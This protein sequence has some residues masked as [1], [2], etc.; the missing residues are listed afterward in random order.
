MNMHYAQKRPW[1]IATLALLLQITGVITI[2]VPRV[3]AQT[4][5]H[6]SPSSCQPSGSLSVL[7]DGTNAISYIPKGNWRGAGGNGVSVVNLEGSRITPTL[8]PTPNMVNSCASNAKSGQ[9][10]CTAN[11]TDVYLLAGTA[12]S[13]TIT[14]G[15]SGTIR[16]TGG[17]CT[18][19]GVAMDADH[20]AAVIGLS[21]AGAPG[22]QFLDLRSSPS[23]EPVFASP[24][25]VISEDLVLDPTNGAQG[26][27]LLSAAENGNFEIVNLPTLPVGRGRRAPQ[28]FENPTSAGELDSTA[29]DCSTGVVLAAAEF[30]GPSN[31]Y[32]VDLTQATFTAGSPTGTWA[33]PSQVQS[34]SESFLSAGASGVAVAQGTHIGMV[35]G[36][37]GGASITAI[38]LPTASGSGIPAINDW[39]TCS[40]PGG[41]ATGDDPHTA[42][43]YKSP[44]TRHAIGVLANEGANTLAAIDLTKMLDT[45]TVARTTSGHGCASGTLPST[46]VTLVSVP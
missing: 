12:L 29:E 25:G 17:N 36:E 4:I 37:F 22:F 20:N 10:V 21:V 33:A 14:S 35:S 24:A 46:V 11:N 44:N 19:C 39:V 2:E 18:N 43:A 23:F 30:S 3:A 1:Q 13:N 26:V 32:I 38:A 6:R 5:V 42:T 16:F 45:T 27:L 8:I 34:L 7:V 31:V 40:I 28:F 15:G 41:F 9:T